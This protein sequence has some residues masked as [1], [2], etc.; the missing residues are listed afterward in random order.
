VHLETQLLTNSLDVLETLLVVG[1]STTDPDLDVVLVENRS[2]LANGTDDTLE[3]RGDVGEVGNTTTDEKNLAVRVHR[4]AQHQVQNGLGV[5]VGLSLGGSTG[6]L[7]V[8]GELADEASGSN[9]VGVHDGSTATSDQSPD[10]AI[11][12]EHGQLERSTSLGIHVG[13]E[14]LLLAQLTTEGSG[15]LH[16]R[17]SINADLAVGLGHGGQAE[18]LRAAGNSPLGTAFEFSSLVKLGGKVKEMH[19]GGGT[20]SVGNDNKRVDLKVGE[21]AVNVDGVEA[22]DEVHQDIV[23]ALGY[24]AQE[25]RSNLLV[26]GVVLQVHGDKKLLGLRINITNVDTTLVGEEDP[27]TLKKFFS[28][29]EPSEFQLENR[30]SCLP[31]ARS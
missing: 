20:L 18:V 28:L 19:I 3:R 21:L 8:V 6:I 2:D 31:H 13:D 23:N 14:L 10:T 17:A 29:R 25:S 26:R 5:V 24:L 9:G 7:T 15:E 12:I 11:G 16:W 1:T 27:V 22:G 30:Q 4:C